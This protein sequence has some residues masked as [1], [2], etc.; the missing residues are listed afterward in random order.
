MSDKKEFNSGGCCG[1]FCFFLKHS[2][3]EICRRLCYFIISFLSCYLA[4]TIALIANT[5]ISNSPLFFLRISEMNDGEIDLILTPAGDSSQFRRFL[6]YTQINELAQGVTTLAPRI[7]FND[8]KISNDEGSTV[9]MDLLVLDTKLEDEIEIGRR[10]S[11]PTLAEGECAIH[12][13]ASNKLGLYIGAEFTVEFN[14][15]DYLDIYYALHGDL[16]SSETSYLLDD[17]KFKCKV[18]S[19]FDSLKGKVPSDDEDSYFYMEMKDFL[20]QLS[21][22]VPANSSVQGIPLT[23]LKDEDPYQAVSEINANHPDRL[24]VYKSSNYDKIKE[25]MIIFTSNIM[26][27]LGF[28]PVNTN[29]PILSSIEGLSMAAV[30]LGIVLNLVVIIL[31]AVS[32]YLVYSLL[33]ISFDTRTFEMG[34]FRLIGIRKYALCGLVI[35]QA[36]IFVIPALIVGISTSFLYL[37]IISKVLDNV[38]QFSF[39]PVPSLTSF[40]WAFCLGLIVPILA[41]VI[42]MINVLNKTLGESIDMAHSKSKGVHITIEYAQKKTDWGI[43]I[44]GLIIIAFGLGVYYLLPLSFFLM[45]FQ[46]MLWILLIVLLAFFIGLIMLAMNIHYL[47]E[48]VLIYGLLVLETAYMKLAIAKN[49]IGHRIRNS[50]TGLIFSSVIGFLIFVIVAYKLELN[51]SKLTM[52]RNHGAYL[53]VYPSKRDEAIDYD[54]V[55]SIE[56]KMAK[57]RDIIDGYSWV[58]R[59]IN[60]LPHVNVN[61]FYA[62]DYAALYNFRIFPVAVAQNFFDVTN[63]DFLSI[64]EEDEDTDLSLAEQMYTPRG[65]QAMGIG[66]FLERQI[67][68]KAKDED[69]TFIFMGK[70]LSDT[71][72]YETRA[73]FLLSTCP[74]YNMARL[75]SSYQNSLMSFPLLMKFTN[76]SSPSIVTYGS[77]IIKAKNDDEDHYETLFNALNSISSDSKVE[78]KVWNY[79]DNAEDVNSTMGMLDVVFY[80]IIIM[81]M[82][83]FVFSLV[84]SMTANVFDQAKELA[85]M[86][87]I[88]MTKGRVA[89]LYL[90]EAFVL[91][92]SSCLIGSIIGILVGFTLCLQRGLYTNLPIGFTVPWMHL[93]IIVASSLVCAIISAISPTIMILSN[94][95]AMLSK[96]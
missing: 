96:S 33:M 65:S 51:Y 7:T 73:L 29:L 69:S 84:S 32:S 53:E 24:K 94:S 5:V 15:L 12:E 6:N 18:G 76:I 2:F 34:I 59:H 31:A 14:A 57:H 28:F 46:L 43:I 78:F 52:I 90:Y 20:K 62:I 19:I 44:F 83:L 60:A 79:Y 50:R 64:F 17:Y 47:L 4:I 81:F 54:L 26:D 80:V 74:G 11:P 45:N 40:I 89:I 48:L 55:I 68:V 71:V 70:R 91:V 56:A 35:I 23:F 22:A 75:F 30:F 42:P 82:L 92:L 8:A 85:V 41:S 77:F 36:L 61:D 72:N 37:W 58:S 93:L 3:R 1:V 21:T 87:S 13:D 49:L 9:E 25:E 67:G 86:R 16:D 39:S 66:S 27:K 63:N 10:F 95:I 88:G 38:F